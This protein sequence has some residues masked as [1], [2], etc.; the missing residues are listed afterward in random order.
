VHPPLL[1]VFPTHVRRCGAKRH[2]RA[3]PRHSDLGSVHNRKTNLACSGMHLDHTAEPVDVGN[4]ERRISEVGSSFDQIARMRCPIE[5]AVVG[6]NVKLRVS[7]HTL[8]LIEH[9]FDPS[10]PA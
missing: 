7:C 10:V 6:V 2:G 3:F 1:S 9:M 5:E 8:T 4:G